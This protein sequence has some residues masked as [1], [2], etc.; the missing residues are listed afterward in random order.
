MST[1]FRSRWR[2]L[3][4]GAVGRFSRSLPMTARWSLNVTDRVTTECRAESSSSDSQ[5]WLSLC[6]SQKVVSASRL[7]ER[8][9]THQEGFGRLD[10]WSSLCNLVD[11]INKAYMSLGSAQPCYYDD[12]HVNQLGWLNC[13][14]CHPFHVS[15]INNYLNSNHTKYLAQLCSRFLRF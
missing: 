1:F 3:T 4:T 8:H 7:R 5:L 10:E 9:Q 15:L 13:T 14:E 11:V 12:D 6:E 2:K